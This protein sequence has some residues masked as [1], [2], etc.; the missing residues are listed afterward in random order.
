MDD[1]G[2]LPTISFVRYAG[3]DDFQIYNVWN[4]ANGILDAQNGIYADEDISGH[5]PFMTL[6]QLTLDNNDNLYVLNPYCEYTDQ[7][8][9]IR[10]KNTATWYQAYDN[11]G[12]IPKEMVIDKHNNIW[13]GNQYELTLTA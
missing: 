5:L 4:M 1:L 2:D 10:V 7:P 11:E 13:I 12:Y 3:N 9:A 6:N 8:I